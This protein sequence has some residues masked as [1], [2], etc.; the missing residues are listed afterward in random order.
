M[1]MNH[2]SLHYF[3]IRHIV[4]VGYAPNIVGIADKFHTSVESVIESLRSL[5][6]YHGVVLHP[7]SNEVWVMHPFSN[8]PTNFWIQSE[9]GSWWGNCAWCS[10][11]A[12]ALLNEDLT[13]TTT[14]GAETQRVVVVIKDGKLL[15]IIY[16]CIFQFLW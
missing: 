16:S 13:I 3:I 11:G 12:A 6:E 2:S 4:D 10:L 7:K 14:L 5:Q 9:S 15:T 1:M 8:A